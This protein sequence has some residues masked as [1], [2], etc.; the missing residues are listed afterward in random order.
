ML[1]RQVGGK[2]ITMRKEMDRH[3][4]MTSG[5]A[6]KETFSKCRVDEKQRGKPRFL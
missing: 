5:S 6:M 1:N 4:K 2:R 3:K